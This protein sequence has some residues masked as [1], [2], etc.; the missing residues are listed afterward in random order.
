MILAL[1]FL[2]PGAVIFVARPDLRSVIGIMCLCSVPFGFTEFLFYPTY[3][4][5]ELLFDLVTVIGFGIEDI[6][7]V[8]GLGAFT[9]TAYAFFT[10]A[11][12]A[13]IAELT[14]RALARRCAAVLA[15]V[16]VC[17]AL[18]AAAGVP[19]I[20]G[21]VAIM[22]G[23]TAFICVRRPDIVGP[24]LLGGLFATAVYTGLCGLFMLILPGVFELAWH[25]D[26]FSNVF[27][28]GI[29]LEELLYAYGAGAAATAFYPYAFSRR[30]V[31]PT[32]ATDA[33]AMPTSGNGKGTSGKG[34]RPHLGER[35]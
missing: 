26:R 15:V 27:I 4:E 29:P 32:H 5:P 14:L 30:F 18:L 7:W 8:T 1:L 11:R 20:Y 23:A 35:G 33:N 34:V 2:I 17:V 16:F 12:Y 22:L 10:R 13:P 31:R 9:S 6:I 28:A 21:S 25:A 19:M 24:A 3:W